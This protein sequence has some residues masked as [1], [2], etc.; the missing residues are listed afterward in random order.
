MFSLIACSLFMLGD[1]DLPKEKYSTHQYEK[2][3][4]GL[5]HLDEKVRVVS[6]NIL[7]NLYDDQMEESYRMRSIQALQTEIKSYVEFSI[8]KSGLNL[9]V[10][11][12]LLSSRI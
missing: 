11:Q 4:E 5:S 10:R 1:L 12:M 3:Q 9:Y 8:G 2:I 6:Y 7:F